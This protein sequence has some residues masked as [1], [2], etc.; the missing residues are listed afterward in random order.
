M[1]DYRVEQP[2]LECRVLEASWR[3]RVAAW[4][5]RGGK[6]A[7]VFGNDIH[8]HQITFN[9]F[10]ADKSLACHECTHVLQYRQYGYFGF[11][12]RYLWESIKHGYYN[13]RFEKEAR[14][15]EKD[16]ALLHRVKFT[17]G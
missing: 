15:A 17:K 14:A 7:I 1:S 10:V 8:L 13:N 12:R 6:T 9:E 3:A 4:V 16:H 5:L 11:L 2:P